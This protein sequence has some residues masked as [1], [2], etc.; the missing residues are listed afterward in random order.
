ME[1]ALFTLY[2]LHSC[3]LLHLTGFSVPSLGCCAA[4]FRVSLAPS[5]SGSVTFHLP[6]D[7]LS[8]VD[9]NGEKRLYNGT[10]LLVFSRGVRVVKAHNGSLGHEVM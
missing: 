10:H 6:P 4:C 7:V 8:L 2:T 3:L 9:E 1:S 5:A